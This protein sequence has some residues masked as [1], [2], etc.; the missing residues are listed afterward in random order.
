[1]ARRYE[2][3]ELLWLRSSPL[4]AKPPG[5]PPIEEW[6]YVREFSQPRPLHIPTAKTD[7]ITPSTGLNLTRRP[8]PSNET[9][10]ILITHLRQL[11]TEDPA[12]LKLVISPVAPIQVGLSLGL[13]TTRSLVNLFPRS[14]L[15]TL[16][17]EWYRRHHP[18]P[19]ENRLCVITNWR[20]W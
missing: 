1:M 7:L 20:G 2:I 6:M 19:P 12:S 17:V 8:K 5:L 13:F 16:V 15:L 4:V 3:D 10:V 18:W 14:S 9:R 11:P